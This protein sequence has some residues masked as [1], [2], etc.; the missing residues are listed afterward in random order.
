MSKEYSKG[1]A[2]KETLADRMK[3]YEA[4]TTETC[5]IENLPIYARVDMRAGHSWCRGLKKP[6]DNDYV[7]AMQ[8]ATKYVVEKTGALFGYTQSDEASFAWKDSTKIPFETRLFKLQSVIASMFTGAF[9]SAC[10]KNSL[11]S[12]IDDERIPSFDCRVMNMPSYDE[13]ANMVLWRERDSVKNSITLLALEYFSTN[14]LNRV[15][16]DQKIQWLKEKK[17]VDYFSLPVH[18][19][20]GSYFRRETFLKELTDEELAVIPKKNWPN[21]VSPN[22]KPAVVRSRIVPFFTEKTLSDL[23]NKAEALLFGEAPVYKEQS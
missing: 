21:V 20:C 13:V 15:T 22:G 8:Y 12:R 14:E 1:N 4:I 2:N 6:F 10:L 3:R 7:E 23:S 19:R 11:K 5:L 16:G 18:L 9:I 17:N